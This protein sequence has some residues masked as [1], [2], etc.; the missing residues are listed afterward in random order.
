[1]IP[2]LNGRNE[3]QYQEC[4]LNT[5]GLLNGSLAATVQTMVLKDT[6]RLP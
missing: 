6:L 1:M 4:R 2:P 3:T 5:Q